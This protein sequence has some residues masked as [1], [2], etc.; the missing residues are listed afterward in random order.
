MKPILQLKTPVYICD[1]E[2]FKRNITD[3][4]GEIKKHY[5]LYHLGYSFKTNYH[6]G[7]CDAVKQLGEYA[8]V[9]SPMEYRYA[10]SLGFKD[11]EIIYNGVIDDFENKLKVALAGGIVNID[12]L[13]EFCKFIE[14][15][16]SHD[17]DI[18]LGIRLNVDVGNGIASRFGIEYSGY[19]FM[20]ISDKSNR[21]HITI[22]SVH[23]HVSQARSLEFFK[24]RVIV[25]AEA[26]KVLGAS[27]IDIG[28][29][30]FGK[31]DDYFRDQFDEYVPTFEE[32]AEVIG[33]TM[34]S[35]FPNK[36]VML[37]TE[38]GTPVCSNAMHLLSKVIAVKEIKGKQMIFLDAKRED[39]G[40]SC[41]T[42]IPSTLNLGGAKECERVLAHDATVFGCTCVEIDYILRNYN[43][44]VGKD[45]MLLIKNIG[46]Y[47]INNC[48]RFITDIPNC[49]DAKTLADFK[50]IVEK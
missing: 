21:K 33:K 17:T 31:M 38:D 43:G 37:I 1:T 23:C 50:E 49:I 19:D 46:A 18:S 9:V 47:S 41:I 3:F 28:G 45:D 44:L 27:I 26:A 5:P 16:D 8:E 48:C 10:K 35:E 34:A 22:K 13:S 20:W 2:R 29:N 40:A 32:Y 11:S 30:M 12:N 14:W 39:V 24:N 25:M 6:K 36:D 7:F 42:K 4:R 15:S